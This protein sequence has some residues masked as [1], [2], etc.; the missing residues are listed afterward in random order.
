MHCEDYDYE[1]DPDDITNPLLDRFSTKRMKVPSRPD[2][3][4][5]Y[6]KLGVGFFS[7]SEVLYPRMKI[8]LRLTRAGPTFYM[9]NE[10]P[11]VSIGFV[12]CSLYT[13]RIALNDDYHKKR[14]NIL[15]YASVEHTFFSRLWE[16]HS[17]YLR[18]KTISLKKTFP[19][20]LPLVD[21]RLQ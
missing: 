6:G 10:N 12:D 7:P 11:N 14:M 21:S 5:L 8:R 4:M 18:G 9:I 16:R 1:Q 15:A 3:F 13:R 2:G 17:S 19:A 20:M